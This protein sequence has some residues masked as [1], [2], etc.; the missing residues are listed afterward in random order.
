MRRGGAQSPTSPRPSPPPG[1]EREI[2]RKSPLRP[3]AER[4]GT[5]RVSDGEG[6]VG[7]AA[8]GDCQLAADHFK[9]A[10]KIFHHL[11]IPKSDH[12]IPVSANFPTSCVV[13]IAL[14]RVLSAIHL[15]RQFGSRESEIDD[16]SPNRVLASKPGWDF[17]L[18]YST[19]EPFLSLCHIAPQIPRDHRPLP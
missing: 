11:A 8:A 14:H 16:K 4:E 3:G 10:R 13:S 6:E 2:V 18:A 9:D 7:S 17:E 5:R 19:P 1:A 12:A 15:D